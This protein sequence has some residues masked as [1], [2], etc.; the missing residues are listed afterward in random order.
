[1]GVEFNPIPPMLGPV[2]DPEADVAAGR[3]I[4]DC[5]LPLFVHGLVDFLYNT[6]S[7]R[8]Q[9]LGDALIKLKEPPSPDTAHFSRGLPY[10][11]SPACLARNKELH[12]LTN[13]SPWQTLFESSQ[14]AMRDAE[15][16]AV[17]E[18]HPFG[19]W[20]TTADVCF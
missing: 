13:E 7:V 4:T 2:P 3:V 11:T 12:K 20:Y 19:T 15:C 9:L 18:S 14:R 1:M 8:T 17:P 10:D 16:T 6:M 5:R